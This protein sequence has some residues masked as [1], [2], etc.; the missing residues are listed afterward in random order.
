MKQLFSTIAAVLFFSIA[1]NAQN[2]SFDRVHDKLMSTDADYA[3]RHKASEER[4]YNAVWGAEQRS[5]AAVRVVPTV[6]HVVHRTGIAVGT[7]E[8]LTDA[9][10]ITEINQFNDRFRHTSQLTFSNPFSGADTEIQLCLATQDPSGSPTTGIVR[11]ASD[12]NTINNMDNQNTQLAYNWPT[13]DY[14]NLYIVH[15]ICDDDSPC[16]TANSVAGYAYLPSSHGQDYDG[17]VFKYS[18]FW[19]GLLAHELGHYF[20]LRH[21]FQSSGSCVNNDCTTDGDAICDTPPK[22][23]CCT[24]PGGCN[25]TDNTCNT[26]EDDTSSNNPFRAV[27]LGGLG[28]QPES[29]E[30]YMD[31]TA[32]CWEAF[33]EGQRDRMQV[34]MDVERVSLLS[35]NGCGPNGIN[36]NE[37]SRTLRFSVSPN[38]SSDLVTLNF[39]SE[40]TEETQYFVRN[41]Y[42]QLVMHGNY[43]SVF[44]RN[45]FQLNLS[46]LADANYTITLEMN[47]MQVSKRIT[48]IKAN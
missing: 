6:I 39:N 4:I 25:N 5:T 45:E 19:D 34:A 47:G 22:E 28:D 48:K 36:D 29:M 9:D 38:P 15:T 1:S 16:P 42:G 2:C 37:N 7:D 21:T 17:G 12:A 32:S 24:G 46:E 31:F 43:K 40:L 30:N 8:N 23:A 11:H 41:M 18:A 27:S 10:I 26:D 44:G 20:G 3:D 14:L 33:T 13:T 35:S